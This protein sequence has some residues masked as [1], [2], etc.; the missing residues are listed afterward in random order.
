MK[1]SARAQAET[2]EYVAERD[3]IRHHI[4]IKGDNVCYTPIHQRNGRIVNK[5]N[6]E[7]TGG[8]SSIRTQNHPSAELSK[9][10]QSTERC[11]RLK[12]RIKQKIVNEQFYMCPETK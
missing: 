12:C 9:Y 2:F 3:P 4:D 11:I 5:R 8:S 7:S 10:R 1:M 6:S